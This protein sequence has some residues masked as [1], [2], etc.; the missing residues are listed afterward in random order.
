[1]V[2]LTNDLLKSLEK[3][4]HIPDWLPGSWIKREAKTAYG[5]R[6]KIVE[7]P[8]QYVQKRM[9]SSV[10]WESNNRDQD[11]LLQESRDN[12]NTGMVSDHITRMERLKFGGSY[13]AE[14]ETALKHAAV[15]AFLGKVLLT[16][17]KWGSDLIIFVHRL[18]RNGL[19]EFVWMDIFFTEST[20]KL[21]VDDIHT[22]NGRKPTRLETCSSGN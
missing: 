9:V 15:T 10:S 5:W 6:N 20:D 7:M 22:C 14:Y 4:L 3:V 13:R 2:K 18:C 19:Y 16:A 21:N 12:V 17:T 1:M 8:Y 11:L